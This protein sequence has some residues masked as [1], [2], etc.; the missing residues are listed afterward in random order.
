MHAFHEQ[1]DLF[2]P[3]LAYDHGSGYDDYLPWPLTYS[4]FAKGLIHMNAEN[5]TFGY[6]EIE[7]MKECIPPQWKSPFL[8]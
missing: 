1:D 5:N 2:V 6:D 4:E 3:F 7:Q 8:P